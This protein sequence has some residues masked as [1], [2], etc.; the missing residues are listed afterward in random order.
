MN[1]ISLVDLAP[2]IASVLGPMLAFVAVSMRYQH[3]DSTRTR[4]LITTSEKAT[5]ELIERSSRETLEKA[6][7]A[8]E[9]TRTELSEHKKDTKE[10]LSELT[11]G[12]AD[13]T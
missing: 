10:A 7:E 6:L 8:I 1:T 13:A 3:V 12:L 2:V 9:R 5:H 11:K 4:R